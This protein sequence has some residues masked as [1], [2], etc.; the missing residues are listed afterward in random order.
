[1]VVGASTHHL[2]WARRALSG[3]GRVRAT[4]RFAWMTLA[5]YAGAMALGL[6]LYPT[7]RLDVRAA[8]LDLALPAVAR[9][10]D[11]KEHLVAVGL[12]AA[13]GAVPLARELD[14]GERPPWAGLYLVLAGTA[15]A[16]AWFGALVGL[17]TVAI[18]AVP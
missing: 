9:L 1:M 11:C 3:A 4:A 12:A 17:Y 13:L 10:F 7:Y 8:Y 6:V 15:C 18:K 16:C 5:A 2:L 14:G